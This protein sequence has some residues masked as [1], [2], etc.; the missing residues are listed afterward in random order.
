MTDG[1]GGGSGGSGNGSGG[2][3]LEPLT[4]IDC[5]VSD[6]GYM[7]LERGRLLRSS[8]WR[9]AVNEPFL[10]LAVMSLWCE[11]WEQVPA[12]SLPDDDRECFRLSRV[13]RLADWK[14]LR[15]SAMHGFVRCADGRL[16]HPTVARLALEAWIDKLRKRIAAGK[17]NAKRWGGSFDPTPLLLRI[18]HAVAL[19][20]GLKADSKLLALRAIAPA[21]PGGSGSGG[22]VGGSGRQADGARS[23]GSGHAMTDV[24]QG[25]A[26][27][28]A[29]IAA[30]RGAARGV[31]L[32]GGSQARS[33]GESQLGSQ[34]RSPDDR[35]KSKVTIPLWPPL[36]GA[37]DNS[38][39]AGSGGRADGP[40]FGPSDGPPDA[41]AVEEGSGGQAAPPAASAAPPGHAAEDE[42]PPT[43]GALH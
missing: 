13:D 38:T 40:P 23:G 35:K 24:R 20:A 42:N 6:Y 7:P 2:L 34:L 15:A 14:R 11:A 22:G 4:P 31:A 18:E 29:A 30:G 16:Y 32:P 21:T 26:D 39:A 3:P 27:V 1:S 17:G 33:L 9:E 28:R 12:G 25:L 37:V 19:L 36:P 5:D 8:T 43:R 41:P 10:A